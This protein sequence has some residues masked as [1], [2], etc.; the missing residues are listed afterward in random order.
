MAPAG[1]AATAP[2]GIA[3]P[4]G[5]PPAG[6]A[7][8]RRRRAPRRPPGRAAGA[9][10]RA[11]E[12]EH[13]HRHAVL[14]DALLAGRHHHVARLQALGDLDLAGLAHA[15]LDLDA[16]GDAG[17]LVGPVDQLDDELAAALRHDGL[18]GDHPRVVALAE[19]RP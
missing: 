3:G 1:A 6:A 10:G 18:L 9:A 19:H 15:D 5:R 16:L 14:L 2:R 4:R 8:A 12:V 11:V 13:A 17:V 7:A